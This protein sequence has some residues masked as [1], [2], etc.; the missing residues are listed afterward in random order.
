[1]TPRR[2][3]E[4]AARRWLLGAL[5]VPLL[6]CGPDPLDTEGPVAGWPEYGGDK[7]GLRYSPLTQITR[8]NVNDLEVAWVHHSGDTSDGSDGTTRTSFNATP[9]LADETLYFCTGFNRVFAVDA[10]TGEER[11]SFDPEPSLE[12]IEGPYSRA[13][14]GDRKSVV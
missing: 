4:R 6:D 5:F 11:W 8:E 3:A 13:C 10:E 1:M 2:S 14:R 9:I 12:K 7:G